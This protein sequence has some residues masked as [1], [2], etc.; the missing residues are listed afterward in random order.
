MGFRFGSSRRTHPTPQNRSGDPPTDETKPG[1]LR[2]VLLT[3][4]GVFFF[5]DS[6]SFSLSPFFHSLDCLVRGRELL[7]PKSLSLS[8]FRQ[9]G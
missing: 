6:P 8:V 5:G 1:E 9:R 4:A 3:W 2:G 7:C